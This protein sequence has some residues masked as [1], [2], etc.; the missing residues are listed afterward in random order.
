MSNHSVAH[1]KNHLSDLIDRA[2]KGEDVVITRHGHPVV[3]IRAIRAAPRRLTHADIDWVD[4][5]RVGK[6]TPG[7]DA[8]KL[9]STL[10]DEW[11]R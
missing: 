10:R 9:L 11:E 5:R 4:K 8:G 2:L 7:Q 3:E 6:V 1:A